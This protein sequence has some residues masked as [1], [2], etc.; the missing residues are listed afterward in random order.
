MAAAG[1][2]I[3]VVPLKKMMYLPKDSVWITLE[4]SLWCV[5]HSFVSQPM[6]INKLAEKGHCREGQTSG[7][8]PQCWAGVPARALSR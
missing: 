1:V 2:C 6:K 8:G 5:P 7:P 4:C 3:A